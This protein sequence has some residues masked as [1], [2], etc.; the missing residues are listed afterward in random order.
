MPKSKQ[1]NTPAATSSSQDQS[2]PL[3][4]RLLK[5]NE[6][7]I[8]RNPN[9]T[10]YIC[11]VCQAAKSR[12][13]TGQ[14]YNCEK[15][16]T[17]NTTHLKNMQNASNKANNT[18]N[19]ED[20]ESGEDDQGNEEDA[21]ERDEDE[22]QD[23]EI[24]VT[25][26]EERKNNKSSEEKIVRKIVMSKKANKS[27]ASDRARDDQKQNVEGF[28]Q[29]ES[30]ANANEV[31]QEGQ[32][33]NIQFK[34]S[35]E[36]LELTF[37]YGKFILENRLPFTIGKPLTGL[38]SF[39][40]EHYSPSLLQGFSTSRQ[41]MTKVA[42]TLSGELKAKIFKQLQTSPFSLCID[43]ASD[44]YGAGYLSVCAKYWD[45]ANPTEVTTKLIAVLPVTTSSTGLTF[46]NSIC[47]HILDGE[48]IQ[49]NFMGICSD[50]AGNMMGP[51][52]GVCYRLQQRFKHI[53]VVRD[54]CHLFNGVFKKAIKAF[55]DKIISL[56][57][58][59][60]THFSD[61]IQRA[62]C[63]QELQKL[64]QLTELEVLS[65][66]NTRWL[67]ARDNITRIL[68]IW[69]SLKL[70]FNAYGT[71]AQK[72]YFSQVNEAYLR[73]LLILTNQLNDY[74]EYFQ[75]ENLYYSEATD[76]IREAFLVLWNIIAIPEKRNMEFGELYKLPFETLKDQDI[77]KG[78]K[79]LFTDDITK[80]D[81]LFA[82]EYL[83]KFATAKQILSQIELSERQKI[84]NCARKFVLLS[85]KQMKNKL[86]YKGDIWDDID[87]I[88][89][90]E[91]NQQKW[92]NLK[93][94]FVNIISTDEMKD[95][96]TLEVGKLETKFKKIQLEKLMVNSSPVTL[97][98]SHK[99]K[100]PTIYRLV[101]A[102]LVL[103]S[104]SAPVERVFSS[105]K[106]IKNAKRNRLSLENLEACLLTYQHY[107]TL[108]IP[109]NLDILKSYTKNMNSQAFNDLICEE[110]RENEVMSEEED[111]GVSDV[112]YSFKEGSKKR[113]T[114]TG[115]DRNKKKNKTN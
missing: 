91:F 103:P 114:S 84:A 94:K 51:Q 59:I 53:I 92:E 70:Y 105:L 29:D 24:D 98:M 107:K 43:A 86:P 76:Q 96:F 50:E 113:I 52:Q 4:R 83:D 111:F 35:N 62:A 115:L 34:A 100:Y 71:K 54:F 80:N 32:K 97:W 56:I 47:S 7:I 31:V 95:K 44:V 1:Q 68:E 46:F 108:R 65:L 75:H 110:L 9:S 28:E 89:F 41:T 12:W 27:E 33:P 73:S 55:P 81:D 5:E 48:A 64:N 39:L 74:N 21:E 78:T 15:H 112:Q 57:K 38:V 6:G 63:L 102:L 19:L 10:G 14:W 11:T 37:I 2:T 88:F 72:N 25:D 85:L 17:E 93:K 58:D 79:K 66:N 104:S 99:N 26:K 77:L 22:G 18:Q 36:E 87:V 101:R 90:N 13:W 61:S 67:S 69:P 60:C 20:E 106:N 8:I 49:N 109:L 3:I 45:E 82:E 23:E 16:L 42:K 40:S 30:V